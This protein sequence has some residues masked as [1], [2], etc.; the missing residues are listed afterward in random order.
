[1]RR[2]RVPGAILRSE[3]SDKTA[4]RHRR[5]PTYSEKRLWDAIRKLGV[6]SAH[7]RRQVPFGA[8]VAD[9]A[10]HSARL[11]IEVDGGVHQLPEVAARDA[12]RDDWL[13]SRGYRVLRFTNRE[14]EDVDTVIRAIA[15]AL[16]ARTPTPGPNPR[17]GGG[18]R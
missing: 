5:R 14:I 6:A 9:F 1:V 16:T 18:K 10:C 2:A 13:T 3:R 4:K 15:G 7:F 17:G 8:Y 12:H 11:I